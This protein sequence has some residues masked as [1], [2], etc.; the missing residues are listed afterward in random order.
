MAIPCTHSLRPDGRLMSV[1][2]ERPIDAAKLA[3][4]LNARLNGGVVFEGFE[5]P[6][7][8]VVLFARRIDDDEAK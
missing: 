2:V 7:G 4:R 3:A 5:L 1:T 6:N 8:D